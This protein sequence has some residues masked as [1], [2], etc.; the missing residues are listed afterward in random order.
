[1]IEEKPLPLRAME[2][3]VKHCVV[4][5]EDDYWHKHGFECIHCDAF[6]ELFS[7][8]KHKDDCIVLECKAFL[9]L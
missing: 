4:S 5:I 7:N 3:V 8:V 2:A 6:A 1:M 9:D